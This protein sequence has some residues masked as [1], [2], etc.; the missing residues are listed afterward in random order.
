[1]VDTLDEQIKPKANR[2]NR[3]ELKYASSSCEVKVL[4]MNEPAVADHARKSGVRSVP[5]DALKGQ[6]V[7]C[8]L[9]C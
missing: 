8:K 5:A 2:V 9:S 4:D 3:R 6:F 1:M 7:D